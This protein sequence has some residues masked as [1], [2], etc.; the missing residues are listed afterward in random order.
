MLA[1]RPCPVGV[2]PR[3]IR[4]G[5]TLLGHLG[6]DQPMRNSTCIVRHLLIAAALLLPA[7]AQAGKLTVQFD[8]SSS[9]VAILGGFIDVHTHGWF[10][11]VRHWW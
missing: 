4:L 2:W 9:T 8:F 3:W 6:R 1:N 10:H 11:T 5:R 7:T